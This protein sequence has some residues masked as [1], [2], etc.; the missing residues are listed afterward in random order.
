MVTCGADR[1]FSFY[2]FEENCILK[3]IQPAHDTAMIRMVVVEGFGG[4]LIT[5]AYDIYVKVW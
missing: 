5:C 4:F 2:S 3:V 1:V